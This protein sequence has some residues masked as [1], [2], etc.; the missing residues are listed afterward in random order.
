MKSISTHG[1]RG[2]LKRELASPGFFGKPQ[3]LVVFID[4]N[5]KGKNVKHQALG[6]IFP[7]MEQLYTQ[8]RDEMTFMNV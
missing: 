3:S 8:H 4:A 5:M 2:F 1:T 7:S 6:F